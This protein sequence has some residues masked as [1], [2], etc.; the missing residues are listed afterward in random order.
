MLRGA[1]STCQPTKHTPEESQK[2]AFST[3]H[4]AR[5]SPLSTRNAT[6]SDGSCLESFVVSSTPSSDAA[7]C[8]TASC[9]FAA[10]RAVT[11]AWLRSPA[12]AAASVRHARGGEWLT[13][14][15]IW[16]TAC[17][18][19]CRFA[20]GCSP[21]RSRSDPRLHTM[22]RSAA[23]CF[24]RSCGS[25]SRGGSDTRPPN[26]VRRRFSLR[27]VLLRKGSVEKW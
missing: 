3:A 20:S 16:W 11:T 12:R 2:R 8:S 1:T 22:R 6:R 4:Y 25:S 18:P 7:S 26:S 21:S 15:R 27:L 5:T 9:A 10:K 17:C 23:R 14:Q 13:R 19:T 24:E